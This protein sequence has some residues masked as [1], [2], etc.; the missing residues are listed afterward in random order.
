M[1][2]MIV[3]GLF[4]RSRS[5]RPSY[6]WTKNEAI[7]LAWAIVVITIIITIVATTSSTTQPNPGAIFGYVLAGAILTF[8]ALFALAMRLHKKSTQRR[9]AQPPPQQPNGPLDFPLGPNGPL[10]PRLYNSNRR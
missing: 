3:Y 9:A 10:Q 5:C 6:K 8:F 4:P 2:R 7:G 1:I